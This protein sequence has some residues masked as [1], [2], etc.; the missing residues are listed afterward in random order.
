M[1]RAADTDGDD[2]A[3]EG[4]P[5]HHH[6]HRHADRPIDQPTNP[7]NSPTHHRNNNNNNNNKRTTHVLR[8]QA[9]RQDRLRKDLQYKTLKAQGKFEDA[10]KLEQ[11]LEQIKTELDDA[12]EAMA[13]QAKGALVACVRACVVVVVV[14]GG[15]G[16]RV[17][18]AVVGVVLL[19]IV[20][21]AVLLLLLLAG[22]VVR[23]GVL[24]FLANHSFCCFVPL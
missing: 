18:V 5:R 23:A 20:V 9:K 21:V 2:A 13:K 7:R 6:H 17:P 12:T 10:Q 4:T 3:Y 11:Q 22:N 15:G 24:S 16:A 19:F 1:V 14:G 8:P